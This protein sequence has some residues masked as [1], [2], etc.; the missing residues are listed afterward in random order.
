MQTKGAVS[1]FSKMD[2]SQDW[3]FELRKKQVHTK[4]PIS[5]HY[6]TEA[7]HIGSQYTFHPGRRQG[8][9]KVTLLHNEQIGRLDFQCNVGRLERT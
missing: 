9:A 5:G 1:Y 3:L 2:E 8:E 7:F 6:G 4:K